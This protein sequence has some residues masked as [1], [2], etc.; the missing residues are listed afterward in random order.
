MS[1]TLFLY[2]IAKDLSD[3]EI[4]KYWIINNISNTVTNIIFGIAFL[5][6]RF[7]TPNPSEQPYSDYTNI[8]QKP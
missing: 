7:S 2:I 8:P 1:S 3:D 5:V 4:K 6:F